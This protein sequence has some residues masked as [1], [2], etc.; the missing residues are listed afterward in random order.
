ML[1]T[2]VGPSGAI[3]FNLLCM[4]WKCPSCR[5]KL[6][7]K[8]MVKIS[9]AYMELPCIQV[10]VGFR[11]ES[12]KKLSNFISQ[13]V[14]SHHSRIN[15]LD[16]S[17][18]I[19]DRKFVGAKRHDKKKFLENTLPDILNHPWEKG[20]RVS[21]SKAWIVPEEKEES[22]YWGMLVGDARKEFNKFRSDGEKKAWLLKQHMY[23][24]FPKWLEFLGQELL[25]KEEQF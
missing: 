9:D 17:V 1:V 5:K 15:G 14:S 18:I 10:F 22:Y 6:I 11:T 7:K 8:Y 16:I 19:S 20:R 21:F 12:G 2:L 3:S 23:R 25:K 4:E 24:K 13:N